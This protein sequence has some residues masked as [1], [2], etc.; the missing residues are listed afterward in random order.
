MANGDLLFVLG[1]TLG[2][3]SHHYSLQG[4]ASY[5]LKVLSRKK[6]SISSK[7]M[8]NNVALYHLITILHITC[9]EINSAHNVVFH[10]NKTECEAC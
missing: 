6:A 3:T 9:A 5:E 2:L 1:A 8:D 4:G 7:N 10:R